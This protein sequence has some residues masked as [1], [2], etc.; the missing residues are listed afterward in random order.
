[1]NSS[2]WLIMS[3]KQVKRIA[4]NNRKCS[5]QYKGTKHNINLHC[6]LCSDL[7]QEKLE[8]LEKFQRSQSYARK[9]SNQHPSYTVFGK[10]VVM[11]CLHGGT[12]S[13]KSNGAR[14]C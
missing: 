3:Y 13:I 8:R 10:N 7:V 12:R 14:K 9:W 4:D 5:K 11:N 1:M 6:S 2:F